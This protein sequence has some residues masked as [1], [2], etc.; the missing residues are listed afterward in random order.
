M[1]RNIKN[2]HPFPYLQSF[3]V[4]STTAPSVTATI[5]LGDAPNLARG[6]AGVVTIGLKNTY[7]SVP[8]ITACMAG[9][10]SGN[11]HAACI[12]TAQTNSSL[13]ISNHTTGGVA[14]DGTYEVISLGWRGNPQVPGLGQDVRSSKDRERIIWCKINGTTG[15]IVYGAQD[16]ACTRSTT[17]TYSFTIKRGFSRAPVVIATPIIANASG[18]RI[19]KLTAKSINAF[20]IEVRDRTPTL[21]DPSFLYVAVIGVD[22]IEE[23]TRE[24]SV[25]QGTQRKARMIAGR[26]SYSGGTPSVTVGTGDFTV[27]DTGTGICTITLAKPFAREFA[28]IGGVRTGAR[29]SLETSTT[30]SV[31]VINTPTTAAGTLADPTSFDFIAIGSDDLTEY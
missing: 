2:A 11:G 5:G 14:S 25:L 17:G 18:Q 26:V 30:T 1:L 22:S 13:P 8:P 19:P 27:A 28:I 10:T 31:A 29:F 24:M 12:T 23:T 21:Q 16:F 20:T 4:V 6:S 9:V 3:S 15:A 7:G